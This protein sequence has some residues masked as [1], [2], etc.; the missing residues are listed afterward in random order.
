MSVCVIFCS[1]IPRSHWSIRT[2]H[3]K[4][5]IHR[6]MQH[7]TGVARSLL[8]AAVLAKRQFLMCFISFWIACLSNWWNTGSVTSIGDCEAGLCIF[9]LK[10]SNI[11]GRSGENLWYVSEFLWKRMEGVYSD[12]TRSPPPLDVINHDT[13]HMATMVLF[14]IVLL[15]LLLFMLL[16][17]LLLLLFLLLIFLLLMSLFWLTLLY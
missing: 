5:G 13:L 4:Q 7:P 10:I 6:S 14:M 12:L 1:P 3:D 11:C 17:L 2:Q 9:L 15:I 8:G 16:L